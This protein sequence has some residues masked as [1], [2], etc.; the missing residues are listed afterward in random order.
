VDVWLVFGR[1]IV[2]RYYEAFIEFARASRKAVIV[3]CGVPIAAE[4]HAALR[5]ANIAVLDDPALCLRALGRIVR[6]TGTPSQTVGCAG[7]APLTFSGTIETDRDFGSV[8]ALSRP[9][10]GS[11]VIRALPATLD[12]LRDALQELAGGEVN[13]DVL[14]RL[15]EFAS[16]TAGDTVELRLDA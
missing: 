3:S 6:A 13:D 12:D 10:G 2:D 11:R 14:D 4:I 15:G 7:G 16:G 8:L 5:D 9:Y 1:P